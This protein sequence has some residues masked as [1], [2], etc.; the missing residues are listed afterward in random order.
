MIKRIFVS[1]LCVIVVFNLASCNSSKTLASSDAVSNA[2]ILTA[3]DGT[4]TT[5]EKPA[6]VG[7]WVELMSLSVVSGAYSPVYV[8]VTNT[9]SYTDDPDYVQD[10]I[11]SSNGFAYAWDHIDFDNED[12]ELEEGLAW[13]LLEYDV[14]VPEDFPSNISG[15][16]GNPSISFYATGVDSDTISNPET[17]ENYVA[18]G[19]RTAKLAT[20]AMDTVYLSGN[21]Y[22]FKILYAMVDDYDD[23]VFRVTSCFEGVAND[24]AT[25]DNI[26]YVYFD[27]S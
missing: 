14:Y 6:S 8:R 9:V 24:D 13:H 7:M 5:A 4:F 18:L 10:A 26:Y 11:D 2:G 17:L 3:L 21:V 16:C 1:F 22:S 27:H 19:V 20:Y 12:Y 15:T 25:D 23:Y